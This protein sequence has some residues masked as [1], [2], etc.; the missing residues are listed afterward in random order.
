MKIT[1]TV[2]GSCV[3]KQRPKFSSRGRFVRAYTPAKTVNYENLV[4][5]SYFTNNQFRSK[6][7]GPIKAE[8]LA[9]Y[10]IP[11][12]TSKKKYTQ[13]INGEI[14]YTKKP[15]VDNIA[16]SI[17]DA[18]NDIA[19]KDDSQINEI[20]IRKIYGENSRT[21]ITLSDS[22]PDYKCPIYYLNKGD[23]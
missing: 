22:N 12:S 21:I 20:N 6:L 19:Y 17:F 11:E 1:F 23:N 4:K 8:V 16:K 3:G 18:L 14:S 2:P 9:I 7:E 5:M 10:P 13:M 15:D